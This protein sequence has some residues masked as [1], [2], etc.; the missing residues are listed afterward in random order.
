MLPEVPDSDAFV[1]L[2]LDVGNREVSVVHQP[3]VDATA[4]ATAG[5][6]PPPPAGRVESLG[7]IDVVFPVLH[8]PYGEDGTVQ[9][10]FDLAGI[11][12]V[13]CG[14]LSSA[15]MMDKHWMKVAFTAA[16]LPVGPYEV[17]TDRQWLAEPQAA[18]ERVSSLRF[19]VFVKPSRAGSSLGITRVASPEGLTAAIEAAREHDPKVI[20]EQGIS[21]R[22]IE[23]GVLGGHGLEPPRA[24][25]P[26]EIVV[27]DHDFYDFEAKYLGEAEVTL[28][29][30]A[31]LPEDVTATIREMSAR[32]FEAAEC[33]GLARC[34]FFVTEDGEVLINEIN[35]MPGFTPISMFPSMWEATGVPYSD[36]ITD[37]IEQAMERREGL[38]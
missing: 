30:P 17:I 7:H 11:R 23:C 24:S 35:T 14:V 27:A 26:G 18:L 2:P 19:P 8:G 13:G 33:E 28:S 4:A 32:A 29:C 15:M 12:Y 1:S 16:D 20:V 10:M 6:T 38:R 34:D 3:A 36:L 31:E 5:A 9:G 21:G 22:E 25:L 37:L